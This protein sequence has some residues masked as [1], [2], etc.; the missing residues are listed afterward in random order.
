MPLRFRF[1]WLL[2]TEDSQTNILILNHTFVFNFILKLPSIN[3]KKQENDHIPAINKDFQQ[4]TA[5]QICVQNKYKKKYFN[6]YEQYTVLLISF[7]KSFQNDYY[8]ALFSLITRSTNCFSFLVCRQ[9]KIL[10]IIWGKTGRFCSAGM[11]VGIFFFFLLLSSRDKHFLAV[12]T[13]GLHEDTDA[14]RFSAGSGVF[15]LPCHRF[16]D[17]ALSST[18]TSLPTTQR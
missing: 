10:M 11:L 4:N 17:G 8:S 13:V 3:K 2:Q 5:V 18:T 14:V 6:W 15:F 16:A 9:I 1:W 12:L 7:Y